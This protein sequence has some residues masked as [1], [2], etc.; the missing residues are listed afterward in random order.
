MTGDRVEIQGQDEE[1]PGSWRL[2]VTPDGMEAAV[3]I[4][5]TVTVRRRPRDV[6]TSAP[7]QVQVEGEVTTRSPVTADELRAA[8]AR[9]G[10]RYG[11]DEDALGRAEQFAEEGRLPVAR[12]KPPL[13][14][15][16]ARVE[17]FFPQE[18]KVP[19]SYGEGAVD[20]RLRFTFTSVGPGDLLARRHPPVPGEAGI[21]VRGEPVPPGQPRDLT[22]VAGRGAE[23]SP[24]GQEV[25]ATSR[26][27]PMSVRKG[28]RVQV[29]VVPELTHPR[30]VDLSTGHVHFKGDVKVGGSVVEG[31]E[32]M[33]LGTVEVGGSVVGA[34]VLGGAGVKVARGIVSSTVVAGHRPGWLSVLLPLLGGVVDELGQLLTA[35]SELLGAGGVLPGAALRL[36]LETRFPQLGATVGRLLGACQEIPARERDPELVATVAGL[37]RV[38]AAPL[39]WQEPQLVESLWRRLQERQVELEGASQ[40][41]ALLKCSYA[42]NSTLQATGDI[43]VTGDGC[44]TSRLFAGGS[45]RVEKAFRGGEIQAGREVWV[46]ALGA[47]GVPARVRVPASGQVR[48]LRAAEDSLVQ[49]GDRVHRLLR[50]EEKVGLRLDAEGK[51]EFFW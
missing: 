12:G 2:E 39:G 35:L 44:H 21:T 46:G 43:L 27:R 10:V 9:A 20:L 50:D 14:P 32:V 23:L 15:Q 33:A 13:P 40:G 51:L 29:Y 25:R 28:D 22:L 16:D 36:L 42:V 45:V 24:D 8:L 41:A 1:R 49:V 30:D 17:L 47:P 11:I 19:V 26:G 3:V 31:M 5:P 34:T 6:P 7:A 48:L 4:S 38:L 18:E 37:K